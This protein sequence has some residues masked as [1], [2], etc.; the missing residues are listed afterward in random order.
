MS[1]ECSLEFLLGHHVV[2]G[3]HGEE[4]IPP[5]PCRTTE[6]LRGEASFCGIRESSSE[7]GKLGLHYPEPHISAQWIFRPCEQRR[8]SAQELLVGSC[9]WWALLLPSTKLLGVGLTLDQLSQ[10]FVLLS[11]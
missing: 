4:M 8:W 11:H 10:D 7:K 2:D 6:L 5:C 3:E 1:P 9:R